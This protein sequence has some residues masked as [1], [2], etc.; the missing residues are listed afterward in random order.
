MTPLKI[1]LVENIHPVAKIRLEQEGFHV[2]LTAHSPGEDELI[3]LV[4]KY[5]ALG[6][7]SKTVVTEKVLKHSQS[8]LTIGCFCIG[9]NQVEL[10]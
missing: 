6:I 1:L 3:E 2:D 7:R 10:S 5:D 4:K 9:T 8:L